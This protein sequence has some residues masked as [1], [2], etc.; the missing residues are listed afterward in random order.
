MA[1]NTVRSVGRLVPRRDM[2]LPCGENYVGNWWVG[3][4]VKPE[5]LLLDQQ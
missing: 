2:C 4:T 5:M 1:D 3:D